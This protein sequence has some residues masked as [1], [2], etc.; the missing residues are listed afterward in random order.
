MGGLDLRSVRRVLTDVCS[1]LTFL[2]RCWPVIVFYYIPSNINCIDAWQLLITII[3]MAARQIEI[4]RSLL[5]CQLIINL[6]ICFPFFFPLQKRFV[7]GLRQYGKNFFRIRKDLLP[8][9]DTV[10]SSIYQ[11]HNSRVTNWVSFDII[12]ISWRRWIWNHLLIK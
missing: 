2:H 9:K 4:Q 1:R 6:L 10:R 5:F 3:L 8:H 12:S 7:K 11:L